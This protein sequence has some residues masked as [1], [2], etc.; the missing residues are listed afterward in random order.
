MYKDTLFS[1]PAVFDTMVNLRH[2]K[3][4]FPPEKPFSALSVVTWQYLRK[5]IS[6]VIS[7]SADRSLGFLFH[8]YFSSSIFDLNFFSLHLFLNFDKLE[9]FQ[10]QREAYTR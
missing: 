3:I 6:L 4:T 2:N 10:F 1:P 9:K 7:L 5:I 8:S